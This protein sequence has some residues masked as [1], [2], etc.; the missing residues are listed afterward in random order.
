LNA[1]HPR[2]NGIA[3]TQTFLDDFRANCRLQVMRRD[4]SEVPDT[5]AVPQKMMSRA[6]SW[7]WPTGLTDL[8]N[9]K[10]QKIS[11]KKMF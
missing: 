1:G 7:N 9:L 4:K 11:W 5:G 10:K 2:L 3:R 6:Q 8:S